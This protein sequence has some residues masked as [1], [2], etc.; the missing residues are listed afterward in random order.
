MAQVVAGGDWSGAGAGD[1]G[2]GDGWTA[3]RR[4]DALGEKRAKGRQGRKRARFIGERRSGG[5][6][7]RE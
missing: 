1:G 7:G 2:T 4:G 5:G 3:W 6:S